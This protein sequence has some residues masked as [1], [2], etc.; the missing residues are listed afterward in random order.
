MGQIKKK[1][2]NRNT[3]PLVVKHR[4][5]LNFFSKLSPAKRKKLTST[6]I[7]D[8]VH[9]ISEICQNFLKKKIPCDSARLK[10]LKSYREEIHNLARKRVPLYKKKKLM[11][12]SRGGA[13]LSVLL[14]LAATVISS[15]LSRSYAK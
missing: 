6:L 9:T 4:H 8:Q 14:P 7:K 11:K 15:L 5:F 1:N 12:S 13:L 10:Q 3:Q 2:N